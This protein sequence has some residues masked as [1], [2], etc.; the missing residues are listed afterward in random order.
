MASRIEGGYHAQVTPCARGAGCHRGA[1][2]AEAGDQSPRARRLDPTCADDRAQLGWA[3]RARHCRG[4]ELPSADGARA[5]RPLQHHGPRRPGRP[6]RPRAQAA[7]DRNRAQPAARLDRRAAPWAARQPDGSLAAAA[8]D[9]P[10]EWT[11]DTLAA[12]AQAAGIQI[13]RS[14][15]R[16]IFLTERVRWRGTRSWATSLDPE[17]APKGRGSSPST[18]VRPLGRRSSTSMNSGR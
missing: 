17:F 4:A 14:Q 7:A 1:P 5:P 2:G 6:T 12:A 3:P 16:R 13:G 15:V 18:P 10:G 11:L 9:Q 8:A